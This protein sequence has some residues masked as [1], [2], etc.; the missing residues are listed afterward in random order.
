MQRM[1]RMIPLV[2]LV[3]AIGISII[4]HQADGKELRTEKGKAGHIR[5]KNDSAIMFAD[6]NHFITQ[7]RGPVGSEGIPAEIQ[8]GDAVRVK[9]RVLNVNHIFWTRYL[10]RYQYGRD[11]LVEAGDVSC[12]LV[13]TEEDLPYGD[14]YRNRLWIHVKQCEVIKEIGSNEGTGSKMKADLATALGQ[15]Q[16][17][18]GVFPKEFLRF[19]AVHQESYLRGVLDSEYFLSEENKDPDRDAL[20]NCLNTRLKTILSVAKSFVEREGE[21]KYLMPWTLSR[22]VGQSCSKET[23]IPS[24]KSPKYTEATTYLKL[25]SISKKPS[26]MM[27]SEEQQDA[28]DKAFLR[29]ALDGSVFAL[30]GH[31]SPGLADYLEC[32]SKPGSLE[33]IFKMMHFH[34]NLGRDLKKSQVYAVAYGSV[35]TCKGINQ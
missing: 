1:K 17:A 30:Y 29:G 6:K 4:W 24:K 5:V 12:V 28:I 7:S 13:E 34:Q 20:V 16:K 9:D 10:D 3:A 27:Y 32:L 18:V 22:L 23:L 26:D 21:Q 15:Y 35:N 8:I 31:S 11:F 25:I 14:E 2:F 33:K 19:S